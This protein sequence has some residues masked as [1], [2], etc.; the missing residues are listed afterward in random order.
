MDNEVILDICFIQSNTSPLKD[1]VQDE[2]QRWFGSQL[3]WYIDS[4]TEQDK[5]IV[6]A[7]VRGQGPWSNE[8]ELL[9]HIEDEASEAMLESIYGYS[10]KIVKKR[11]K[12]CCACG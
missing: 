4:K 1:K 7:E 3:N 12:G 2:L 5:Q 10:V 6:V 9:H 8:D 11:K